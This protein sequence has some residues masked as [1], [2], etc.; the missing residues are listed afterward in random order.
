LKYICGSPSS[1]CIYNYRIRQQAAKSKDYLILFR[2]HLNI[3]VSMLVRSI[4]RLKYNAT[5]KLYARIIPFTSVLE[6]Y[7]SRMKRKIASSEHL[8]CCMV[9]SF[10]TQL[11]N[12]STDTFQVIITENIDLQKI[13]PTSQPINTY[14]EGFSM[15]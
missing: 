1:R 14:I 3:F 7:P 11:S 12:P 5:Y 6:N 4:S 15:H 10:L 13:S 8:Y 2:K 9:I